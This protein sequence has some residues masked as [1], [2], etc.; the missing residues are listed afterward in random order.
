M[1]WAT[2]TP[3]PVPDATPVLNFEPFGEDVAETI[4]QG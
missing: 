4:V 3:L 1:D 2:P